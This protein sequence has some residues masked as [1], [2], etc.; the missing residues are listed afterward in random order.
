[1]TSGVERH[2]GHRGYVF[3][4]NITAHPSLGLLAEEEEEEEEDVVPE[5][6]A[7]ILCRVDFSLCSSPRFRGSKPA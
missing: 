3:L 1:M 4:Y 5:N 7:S 6:W 2:A